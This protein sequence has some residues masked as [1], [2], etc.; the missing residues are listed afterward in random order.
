MKVILV[1]VHGNETALVSVEGAKNEQEARLVAYRAMFGK[2]AEP[3]D[4]PTSETLDQY[5]SV[6]NPIH[7]KL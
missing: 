1:E 2:A 5:T 3:A 4:E 6:L 7:V